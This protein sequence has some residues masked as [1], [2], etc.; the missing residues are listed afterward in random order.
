MQ[1]NIAMFKGLFYLLV[2]RMVRLQNKQAQQCW[3][4]DDQ[5]KR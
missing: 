3:A 5:H 1:A 2:H 4:W